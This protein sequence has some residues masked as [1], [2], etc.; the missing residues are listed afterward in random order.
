L[1]ARVI[2]NRLWQQHF[3]TGIVSTPSDMGLGGSQPSHPELL[4]WLA[5]Q[6]KQNQ[7]SL[8]AM[9]RLIC[10]SAAYRQRSTIDTHSLVHEQAL[11][12][13]SSNR[14]LWRQNPRRLDAE[15]IRDSILA[16]SGQ[17]D[18]SMY[19]PGFREFDY[20]EEYAPVYTYVTK[21]DATLMRRS[22]YRFRVRTTPNP[23]LTTLDCPN[24]ANLTPT[25]STTTT[26]IQSLAML[27][28]QFMLQQADALARR[29][30][31]TSTEPR[32]QIM[33]AWRLTLGRTP[34]E[35][36]L[37]AAQSLIAQ[38]GTITFC[39]YLLNANEFVTVD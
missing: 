20:K 33:Q 26:A 5:Q 24:P 28:H 16:V 8:K 9:H 38:H 34:R 10:C 23:L 12:V 19:G 30:E 14:L 36:E 39:R 15:A 21:P 29:L 18:V 13:D 6:L 25:R 11:T 7:Y 31:Q 17:L 37:M 35:S 1:F 4:D 2:V 27:N 32:E 22:I 3:G